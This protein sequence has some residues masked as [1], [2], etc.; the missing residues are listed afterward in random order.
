[1]ATSETVT[2]NPFRDGEIQISV[3][4]TGPQ[5]EIWS[6]IEMDPKANLCYNES[7]RILSL[8]HI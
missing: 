6:T 8:I 2:F 1:M 5:K 4:T 3:P 7:L